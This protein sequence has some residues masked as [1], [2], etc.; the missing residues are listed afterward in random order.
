MVAFI[1]V[2]GGRGNGD[3]AT[4]HGRHCRLVRLAGANLRC[5][6]RASIEILAAV[7]CYK[8]LQSVATQ[9]VLGEEVGW[10]LFSQH[11]TE[12]DAT[13][14]DSLLYPQRVRVEMPQFA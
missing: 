10:V 13:R 11:F 8:F 3:H 7:K 5:G 2:Y 14:P 6:N 9:T 4:S 1:S 12:I